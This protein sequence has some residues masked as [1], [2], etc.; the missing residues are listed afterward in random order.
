MIAGASL[1][2]G[3]SPF[4]GA[5]ACAT[6]HRPE[7]RKQVNSRHFAAL[8]PIAQSPVAELLKARRNPD[9]PPAIFEWAFG[10]GAQGIT[11]VGT[12]DG[13]YF[14]HRFSYFPQAHQF[15]LTFGHPAAANTALAKLGILQDNRTV[16]Q[17]FNCHATGVKN[18]ATAPDLSNMQPGVSCER[19]HGPG[20]AHVAAKAGSIMNPARLTAKAQVKFCGECHRLPPAGA[21]SPEPEIED[22]VSV[23]FAPIGLMASRCFTQSGKLSCTTCHDPHQDARPRA[24]SFYTERCLTCHSACKQA[25]KEACV[26]CHMRK[27]A[28]TPF[29]TFTDH[30]IRVY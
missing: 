5:E 7:Y 12:I 3:A 8:R 20:A 21:L 17:C 25:K 24:N 29:L 1:A 22:P 15:A 23:R 10:A 19:C 4:V 11:P 18:G 30:R 28:L 9:Q 16:T 26:D 2:R 27:A 6:C 14:E 13:Q